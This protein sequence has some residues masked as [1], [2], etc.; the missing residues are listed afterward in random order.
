MPHLQFEV[1]TGAD[2]PADAKRDFVAWVTERYAEA[3]DTTMGHIAVT[4]READEASLALGRASENEPV[5]V[6]NADIRAGRS[7]DQRRAFAEGVIS[8]LDARF[9]VPASNTYVIYTEHP[10]LDFHL[11]EGPLESWNPG[12]DPEGYAGANDPDI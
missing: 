10:G 5:V 9:S 3:M 8:E 11:A 7:A 6:L 1:S 12:D 2:L 4:I